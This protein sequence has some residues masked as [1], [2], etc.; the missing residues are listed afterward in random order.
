MR[1][2][3][4]EP[5]FSPQPELLEAPNTETGVLRHPGP[6]WLAVCQLPISSPLGILHLWVKG[7]SEAGRTPLHLGCPQTPVAPVSM[8]SLP[9]QRK[10]NSWQSCLS[11]NGRVS[12]SSP[13]LMHHSRR[14]DF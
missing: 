7:R 5:S 4:V 6:P 12:S 13:E 9:T 10:C 2:P 11:A 1:S 8:A 14:C 3:I